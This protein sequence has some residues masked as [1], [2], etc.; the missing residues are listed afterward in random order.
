LSDVAYDYFLADGKPETELNGKPGETI[1]LRIVDGSAS[2][3][4]Q[5]EYAGGQMTVVSADGKNVEPFK[6]KRL[7]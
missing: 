3:F 7:F 4:F 6:V 5:L 2:S 1:R